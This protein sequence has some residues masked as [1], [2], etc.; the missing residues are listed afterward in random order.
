M[1]W[2]NRTKEWCMSMMLSKAG[3]NR[4]FWRSSRGVDMSI[5]D[6]GGV[7]ASESDPRLE[8]KRKTQEIH[9]DRPAILQ[10]G[11]LRRVG[12]PNPTKEIGILHGRL[13]INPD[14]VAAII[15][16]AAKA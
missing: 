6:W 3:R 2:A 5:S 13:C 4:S 14:A 15:D 16:E 7:L 8:R 10:N 11:I 9:R 12:S 1:C